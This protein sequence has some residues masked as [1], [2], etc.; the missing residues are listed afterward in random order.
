MEMTMNTEGEEKS[1]ANPENAD[2]SMGGVEERKSDDQGADKATNE[3]TFSADSKSVEPN[4]KRGSY[5]DSVLRFGKNNDSAQS[6][7]QEEGEDLMYEMMEDVE[8]DVVQEGKE[9]DPMNPNLVVERGR[10]ARICVEV[11]LSKHLLAK[12][13]LRKKT[14]R[15][16]YEG[17]HMICF[18]CGVYGHR[19]ENCPLNKKE[20]VIDLNKTEEE[21]QPVLVVNAPE[22][23]QDAFG[24]WM[25]AKKTFRRTPARKETV[26]ATRQSKNAV[27][28]NHG[29]QGT[30]QSS[31]NASGS[32]FAAISS[33]NDDI[34]ENPIQSVVIPD[35]NGDLLTNAKE[36]SDGV[37]EDIRPVNQSSNMG[38]QSQNNNHMEIP[39]SKEKKSAGKNNGKK[40]NLLGVKRSQTKYV[41]AE[42]KKTRGEI[43]NVAKTRVHQEVG[44]LASAKPSSSNMWKGISKCWPIVERNI[45]WNIGDG[46]RVLF[47][48][49]IWI[50][51]R[52]WLIDCVST[53]PPESV[54]DMPVHFFITPSGG[55]DWSKIDPYVNRDVHDSIVAFLPPVQG[56]HD[57]VR[58]RKTHDGN[59]SIRLAY[60]C[61]SPNLNTPRPTIW[62]KIWKWPVHERI[63]SFIW[64]IT[65]GKILTNSHRRHRNL[66]DNATCS[67][68]GRE[69]ETVL[70]ALR[71]CDEVAELWM[72]FVAPQRWN[73]FFSL[74]LGD[75]ID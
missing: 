50:S 39:P 44:H 62:S 55:W 17:L 24:S 3:G 7:S 63:R 2:I 4:V 27:N 11:D 69:D 19:K 59:F 43:T 22:I 64:L 53:Q 12:F 56:R 52:G 32:R 36:A 61:L 54:V 33:V 51:D 35:I 1:Q 25:H 13:T 28:G 14:R 45:A 70:Y 47:W 68:C 73:T 16:E 20:Q 5:R 60:D 74:E 30:K 37:M 9:E 58:W 29:N 31:I 48:K 49:D 75:W 18:S 71:D 65:H 66:T 72:R 8:D 10:F 26:P 42:N 67:R 15:I 21:I 40:I 46:N 41:V 57:C 6:E 23:E 34:L 38:T